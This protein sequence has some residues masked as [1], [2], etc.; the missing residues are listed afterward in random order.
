MKGYDQRDQIWIQLHCSEVAKEGRNLA[1]LI[2]DND[3]YFPRAARNVFRGRKSGVNKEY[4]RGGAGIE[5]VT[6]VSACWLCGNHCPI[7][8]SE[9]HIDIK[10][11][12]LSFLRRYPPF[13]CV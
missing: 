3:P 12:L 5:E 2:G 11:P 8:A 13:V 1:T 9:F 4:V 10:N 7:R 6:T